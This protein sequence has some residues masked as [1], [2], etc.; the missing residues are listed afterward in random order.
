MAEKATFLTGRTGRP[1]TLP[2]DGIL[3]A[4]E[5]HVG[6]GQQ[7][8]E[9]AVVS[10]T[11]RPADSV[12]HGAWEAR[13]ARRATPV[14][15]VALYG[16]RVAICGPTG[17]KPPVNA[18]LNAGQAERL[19]REALNQPDRHA[20][21]R[22]LAQALPSLSTKLPGLRNEGLL[23]LHELEHGPALRRDWAD[24]GIRAKRATGQ[25]GNDLLKALGFSLERLDNLTQLL[26]TGDRRTALAVLLNQSES[27]EASTARF[28]SISPISYALAKADAENLPWVIIVQDNRIRLYPTAVG[29]GVGRRGRT[30]TFVECQPA[31]LSDEHLA[32]LWLLFSADALRPNGSL[33]DLLESSRRFAG[34]LAERLRDRIYV[35]V[36]P[37][38]ASG[39]CAARKVSRYTAEQLHLSYQM[40]L[41]VLFRLL[42]IAYAEDRDLLPY[43]YN[44]A[45][46]RRSL[47]QKALELAEAVAKGTPLATGDTHWREVEQLWDAVAG[48]NSEWG[49][50]AYDGGLFSTDPGVSPAGAQLAKI[51][52]SNEIFEPALRGLLLIE[53]PENALGPVDFRSLG[54]REFG[55]IYEGLLESELSVADADLTLDSKGTYV[56]AKNRQP[57]VVAEGQVYL[58]DRSGAR[59]SSG[60]YFTKSFAVEHLLDRALEPALK[61]HFA[62]LD[63]LDDVAAAEGFFD[64]RVADIAMGSGHFLIAAIDRIERGMGEYLS[65]RGLVG[66]LKELTL[67]RVAAEKQLGEL[68]EQ[69]QIEDGQLLRRLIARRC[70]YGVDIND[71]SVQLARLSI[72]I[73]TFV[74]G[75][76][77]S[78]LD[79]SLAFGNSLVGVATV[80]EIKKKFNEV[81]G[82]LFPVDADSL[83]GS[84]A[85][86]LKRL[87][88]LADASL[89]DVEAA[90]VAADEATKAIA[91]TR[92]LCDIMTAMPVASDEIRFQFSEWEQERKTVVGGSAHKKANKALAGLNPLH[93]PIAFPEV[94]LRKRPGFDVMVGNPPWQEVT[95]EEHA[96]WARHFPGLRSLGQRE[97]EQLKQE[98]RR[99]RPDLV[100]LYEAELSEL[101]R[102]RK[103]LVGGSYPGM[104]TGDPDLY[105]AFCWRFW[106]LV[107]TDGGRIGVVL[108]RSALAAKGTFDFRATVF[109]RASDVNLTMLLNRGGWVFDEAE[110]RYTIGLVGIARG[111]PSGKSIHLKGP[112]ASL[113]AFTAGIGIPAASFAPEEVL[114]WNDT[115]SLP[116]LPTEQSLEVFAQLRK[117]PRLDLNDGKSWRA[118]PDTELH[119]TAQKYLMDLDSEK[120]PKGFWPVFKGE[121]FDLWTPDTG[122]YYAWADPK[123]VIP[124]VMQKRIS[125]GRR[126]SDSA[127]SEFS[128]AYLGKEATLPCHAPRIAFRDVTRSTDTRT[129]RAALLPPKVFVT[130]TAPC[131]LWPR[132]DEKDQAFLLGVLSAIPLDWY[133]RRFVEIHVNFF[134]FNPFPVPRPSRED[135]GWQRVVAL[136]GRLACPD[137]RFTAWAKAV[138]VKV[139]SLKDVEKV[140]MIHELDAVVAHLYGLSESQLLHIFE[141]FHEGWDYQARLKTTLKHYRA[142]ANKAH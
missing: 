21:L 67:L 55:T 4:V 112:Y 139:G 10:A 1:L 81:G 126:R 44:E 80:D 19:C 137:D 107:A 69:A 61:D 77:L 9:I 62:R 136:A 71:L 84:A 85:Q 96:F 121:S 18:D 3:K 120:C 101:E 33:A 140:D 131:L 75:L 24:A 52:L 116:L 37:R 89:K 29:V 6:P 127:H 133:S 105:K 125:S 28:N 57:V 135:K 65:R 39:I 78:L 27:V 94:F 53:T 17:E 14:L 66:V 119:A 38:L 100:S 50:P 7:G 36:V 47:K 87:A 16:D 130:N 93:F 45:Y 108:P 64:F 20:A 132:G 2:G 91:P 43:R 104:G 25:H 22:F 8:L 34:E 35:E 98:L 49:V 102:L 32:Y 111:A 82:G 141:T 88:T 124:W 95:I 129:V 15:L 23:A 117:S 99:T 54:V 109:Q 142:W 122:R 60:S 5:L 118:R 113:E 128:A 41:T 114:S 26:R 110:H 48:G 73:H 13:R 58:H 115:A 72:W 103:I 134:V 90:R 31:L 68:A 97:Q 63:K 40:A 123:V 51:R 70:I 86:P 11:S 12:L 59:K 76:P 56:P 46:K 92:A 83:L 138:G 106:N 74:P 30:E 79:H 42:F